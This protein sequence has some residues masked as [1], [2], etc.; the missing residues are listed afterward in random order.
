MEVVIKVLG[1]H[2]LLIRTCRKNRTKCSKC[3]KLITVANMA[4]HQKSKA[5]FW[6]CGLTQVNLMAQCDKDDDG[7]HHQHHHHHH[8]YETQTTPFCTMN[9]FSSNNRTKQDKHMSIQ[10]CCSSTESCLGLESPESA[11]LDFFKARKRFLFP[12]VVRKC[13]PI[14]GSIEVKASLCIL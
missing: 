14:F 10:R 13:I 2:S 6:C 5:C 11:I 3:D 8:H 4:R 9:M 12:N 1:T 7:H